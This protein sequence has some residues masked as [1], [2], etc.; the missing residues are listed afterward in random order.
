MPLAYKIKKDILSIG[1]K[2]LLAAA[3]V[4]FA[5]SPLL[6]SVSLTQAIEPA[7][8]QT[9]NTAVTANPVGSDISKATG[10][11]GSSPQEQAKKPEGNS[12]NPLQTLA[13][14]LSAI[15]YYVF[16]GLFSS[17]AYISAAFFSMAVSVTLNSSA[18]ALS[19]I[20]TAWETTRD[21]ANMAFIFILIYIAFTVMLKAETANTMKM[22]A[23]VIVVALIINFSFFLTRVV[24]DGGNV[25]AIQFY[26]LIDQGE[27]HPIGQN[28]PT[29][30][31]GITYYASG[32]ASSIMGADTKDLTYSIMS[33]LDV[34]KILSSESYENFQKTLRESGGSFWYTLTA[35]SLIYIMV[36]IAFAILA[37]SFLFAGAKFIMRTVGLIFLIIA[38]PLALIGR[39]LNVPATKKMFDQWLEALIKYSFYPAIYLFMFLILTKFM[40]ELNPNG[41]GSFVAGVFDIKNLQNLDANWFTTNIAIAGAQVGI[42]LGFVIAMMY[43]ALSVADI[44]VKEGGSLAQ[45]LGSLPNRLLRRTG[46]FAFQQTAGRIAVG[47]G[48]SLATGRVGALLDKVPGG[49]WVGDKTRRYVA[50]PIAEKS[51]GGAE[52]RQ[53]LI[54]R[55][56]KERKER[57]ANLWTIKNKDEVKKLGDLEEKTRKGTITATEEIERQ[58][59]A[60]RVSRFG[61]SD[62][63]VFKSG[64]LERIVRVLKEDQIKKLKESDKYSDAN[65]E[66]LENE[67]HEQS[68][69]AP[70]KKANKQIELLRKINETLKTGARPVTV[71]EIDNRVGT[72]T[73]PTHSVINP[74]EI[75]KM[76]K[77]IVKEISKVR[78]DIAK[79]PR[80]TATVELQ[81][82]L[83]NLQDATKKIE[84]LEEETRKIPSKVGGVDNP[85]EFDTSKV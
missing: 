77:D 22:L 16:V 79:T 37:G 75:D 20:N 59:I 72:T 73:T 12:F 43:I 83:H 63:E 25:L 9:V 28:N 15:I 19:F 3:I 81:Q 33:A 31:S 48:K 66:K 29:N 39:A 55:V 85:G 10:A 61:K 35:L 23:G 8:P 68:T 46:G 7:D 6:Q 45:K 58:R 41:K 67:W 80:G 21:L 50:Q 78:S 44:V 64:E 17:I 27:Y 74:A 71:T 13:E 34:T 42:R 84:K 62:L 70:L 40:H 54:D 76:K 2:T 82:N 65:K 11:R 14:W 60:D 57:S 5:F 47:A 24:I 30:S 26:N 51:F 18:Y 56:T 32:I 36:G 52:S 69:D 1:A 4:M 49:Y 38:A 53:Q